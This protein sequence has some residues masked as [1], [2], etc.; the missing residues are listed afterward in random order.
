MKHDELEVLLSRV[1]QTQKVFQVFSYI[2]D[3]L[4]VADKDNILYL[5]SV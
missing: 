4:Y 3:R 5:K 1:Y 2:V